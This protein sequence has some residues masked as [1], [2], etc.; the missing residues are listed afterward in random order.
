MAL[1]GQDITTDFVQDLAQKADE[2]EL[3]YGDPVGETLR[4]LVAERDELRRRLKDAEAPRGMHEMRAD[5]RRIMHLSQ[6]WCP[7]DNSIVKG[8]ADGI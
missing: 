3:D 2:Q 7:E 8:E 1:T 6:Q 5:F 4:L